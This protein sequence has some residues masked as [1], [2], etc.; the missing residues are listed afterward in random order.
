DRSTA[1]IR[2]WYRGPRLRNH[3]STSSSTRREIAS[4]AT[5]ITS[6]A[7]CQKS[8][9]KSA[10]SGGEVRAISASLIDRR[11][12]TSARPR[13]GRLAAFDGLPVRL[14]LTAIAPAG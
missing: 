12:A 9:G 14:A 7:P 2:V 10:S 5:G 8:A 1:F 4:L 6:V 13:D 11:R 3:C